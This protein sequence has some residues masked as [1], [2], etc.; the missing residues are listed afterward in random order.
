MVTQG[1]PHE[2]KEHTALN[3]AKQSSETMGN[4]G[5][6]LDLY[7]IHSATLDS[8]VLEAEDVLQLL[9]ELKKGAK[10]WKIGLSLSGR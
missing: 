9:G 5:S 7:Q 8:G 6:Y 3:L 2:V 1:A 10:R 4:L